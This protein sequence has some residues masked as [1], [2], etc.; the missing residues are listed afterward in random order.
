MK[1]NKNN[2]TKKVEFEYIMGKEV[3]Q[4]DLLIPQKYTKKHK[5]DVEKWGKYSAEE[6][7]FEMIYSK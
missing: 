2:K 6:L 5:A 1:K 7:L 4:I 3:G